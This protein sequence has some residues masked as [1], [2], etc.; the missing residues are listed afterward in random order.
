M[1]IEKNQIYKTP[2]GKLL[3]LTEVRDSGFHHLKEI[4]K[5]GNPVEEK[6]NRS[7]HVVYRT[8]FVY[9]EETIHSFKKQKS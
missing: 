6:R 8:Y 2:S 3:Q 7:G 1:A 4:D 5:D 9:S